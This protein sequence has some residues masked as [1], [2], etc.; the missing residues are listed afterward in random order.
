MNVFV[1]AKLGGNFTESPIEM[2]IIHHFKDGTLCQFFG[3][4]Q[5]RLDRN[6]NVYGLSGFVSL[7]PYF[8]IK[9]FGRIKWKKVAVSQTGKAAKQKYAHYILFRFCEKLLVV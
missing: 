8:P 5:P 1:I 6:W 2:R 9:N 4:E 3:Q 7:F